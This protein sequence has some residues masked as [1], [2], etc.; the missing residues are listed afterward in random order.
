MK[1]K[2]YIFILFCFCFC[3]TGYGRLNIDSLKT[4]YENV[5][6][7]S[8]KFNAAYQLT[9]ALSAKRN[10]EAGIYLE[11]C[12]EL[13]VLLGSPVV[14]ARLELLR[15]VVLTNS[16][17]SI[18]AEK[19]FKTCITTLQE[20]KLKF[21]LSEAYGFRGMNSIALGDYYSSIE[22]LEKGNELSR[23]LKNDHQ[24]SENY[25][26]LGR[27]YENLG[28]N[29]KGLEYYHQALVLAQALNDEKLI[30]ETTLFIGALYTDGINEVVGMKYLT[31]AA[32]TAERLKDTSMLINAYTFIAN[33]YYYKRDYPAALKMYEKIKD[34]CRT[35]GSKNTYAGTLGNLGNVYA[36]M[37]QL[38]KAMELQQEAVRIFEEIGDKQGL[39]IC[40]SAIGI[41]Y[42]NLKNYDKALEYFNRSLPMAVEMQSR[43]DLIE[44]HQ[45]LARLYEEKGEYKEA[46]RNFKLY[47][48]FSDSVYNTNNSQRI[49]EMELNYQFENKQKETKLLQALTQERYKRTVIIAISGALILLTVVVLIARSSRQRKKANT[50]LTLSN[51]AIR[52]QKEE[53][54][55]H[56]KEITDSINYAKRIQ[57]S[58]LP[59]DNYWK[60]FL[61]DSFIFYRP[62][63]IVSGDF[64]WIEQKNDSVCFAAVDCTG[65]GVPGALMSVVGF[66]LLT[67]AVNEMSLTVPSEILKHL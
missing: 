35:H 19:L 63:D 29:T 11:K 39:T 15:A 47:K 40:Y 17:E 10:P 61:P 27:A 49:A 14:M 55:T 34:F 67:Q 8:E 66:N 54:E 45:N 56:K 20:N 48:Q 25:M 37:G 18:E 42:L 26:Y 65:H 9:R 22:S 38:E 24:L 23:E 21:E 64:Y 5:T 41:D 32:E 13:A 59:P 7:P 12:S 46:Y 30:S 43:E 3:L 51:T 57:E 58:I 44:I 52:M 31:Q 53:L 36:D 33:N 4:V 16:G 50:Q 6:D 1:N 28:N 2:I 60:T 62:K